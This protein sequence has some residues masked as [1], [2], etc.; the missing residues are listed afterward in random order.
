MDRKSEP[1]GNQGIWRLGFRDSR[2]RIVGLQ[3]KMVRIQIILLLV[4]S[5]SYKTGITPGACSLLTSH[6]LN[7]EV[8]HSLFSRLSEAKASADSQT[9]RRT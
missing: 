7:Q 1:K 4:L 6:R 8:W 3:D 5:S 2:N 9:H